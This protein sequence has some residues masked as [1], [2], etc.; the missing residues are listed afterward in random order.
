MTCASA[1]NKKQ[2]PR[3]SADPSLTS[4]ALEPLASRDVEQQHGFIH[5]GVVGMIADSAGG[6]AAMTLVPA[7]ASEGEK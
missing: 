7:S 6:Y 5:G 2:S 3:T 4:L 1:S